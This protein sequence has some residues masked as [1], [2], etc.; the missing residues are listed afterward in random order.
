EGVNRLQ[1]ID[2]A[3]RWSYC[4]HGRRTNGV[5]RPQGVEDALSQEHRRNRRRGGPIA[6]SAAGPVYC[7]LI[8]QGVH[9]EPAVAAAGAGLTAF[10]GMSSFEPAPLLNFIV[11]ERHEAVGVAVRRSSD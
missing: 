3:A 9:G 11:R 4:H 10:R 2:L 7:S 6:E 8:P 1:A 5:D